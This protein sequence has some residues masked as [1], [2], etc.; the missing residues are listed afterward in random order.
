MSQPRRLLLIACAGVVAV[1]LAVTAV[2]VRGGN[3]STSGEL[4]LPARSNANAFH[5]SDAE[6]A[7]LGIQKV[8]LLRFRK[9]IATDG[10]IV[11]DEDRSTPIFS[12][13]SGR[14]VRLL[15]APGETIH[16][17][18]P[19]FVIAAADTVQAQNDFMAALTAVNKAQAQVHLTEAAERR[20]RNLYSDKAIALK[21]WQQ[22]QADAVS[23]QNDLRTAQTTVAAVRNRLRLLG[24]TDEEIDT[25]ERTGA[26]S[27]DTTIY[28]PIGGTVLQRKVG[29]GQYLSAGASDPV[30]VIGDLSTVWLNAFVRETDAPKVHVGQQI[31]FTTLSTPDRTFTARIDYAAASIDTASRRRTVRANLENGERL[32]G[33]EM[34][35]SVKIVAEQSEPSPAVPLN[36][37]LYEGNS[38]RVWVAKDDHSLEMRTVRLG[39]A[40]GALIQVL[41]G[42]QAGESIVARGSLF[43]DRVASGDTS[44]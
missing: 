39:V 13:Y 4:K 20:L 35:A 8:A 15:A 30:Y 31:E 27:A 22:A 36:A 21:D 3:G 9:E 37:V 12:P 40:N 41:D 26:I 25:F 11:V 42:L 19:L 44:Q 1:T 5:A 18:Q 28:A 17:G 33:P 29:P 16:K 43:I 10:K 32:F 24:K 34:F 2:V 14:V 7:T 6:W 23:A 38:T